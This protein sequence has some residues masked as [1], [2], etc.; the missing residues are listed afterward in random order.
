[1]SEPRRRGRIHWS[2]IEYV[3]AHGSEARYEGRTYSERAAV[4]IFGVSNGRAE[5]ESVSDR[6]GTVRYV[7][8]DESVGPAI[9]ED[10]GAEPS[11]GIV[12]PRRRDETWRLCRRWS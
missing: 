11:T 4:G 9:A 5:N 1:M 2:A 6:W 8:S 10:C 3:L 12:S 7:D